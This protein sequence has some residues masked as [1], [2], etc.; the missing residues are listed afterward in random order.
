MPLLFS[1]GGA[2]RAHTVCAALVLRVAALGEK[3][4]GDKRN[5]NNPASRIQ[6]KKELLTTGIHSSRVNV[7]LTS[8]GP[9]C[10]LWLA[11][12]RAGAGPI[13]HALLAAKRAARN[14]SPSACR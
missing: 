5:C 10:R 8:R 13:N 4:K 9:G 7:A 11:R 12:W 3:R 2:G 6:P 1:F 14:G